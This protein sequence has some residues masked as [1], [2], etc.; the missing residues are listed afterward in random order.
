[1]SRLPAVLAG[2]GILLAGFGWWGVNTRGGRRMFDEMAGMIPAASFGLGVLL[3][4]AGIVL[5][6]WRRSGA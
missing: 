6:L 2:A 1:V 5:G 3:I 4:V